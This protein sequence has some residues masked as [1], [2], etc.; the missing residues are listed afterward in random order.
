MGFGKYQSFKSLLLIA[1]MDK[2]LEPENVR[3]GFALHNH[4][5][6][7]RFPSTNIQVLHN[8]F[9]RWRCCG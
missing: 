5:K 9:K 1:K 3:N 6:A 4:S 8:S 7:R 2:N